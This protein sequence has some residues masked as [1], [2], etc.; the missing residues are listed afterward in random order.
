LRGL[1]RNYGIIRPVNF[2]ENSMRLTIITFAMFATISS[3]AFAAD[4]Q[5]GLWKLTLET[6]VPATPDFPSAPNTMNQCM[7]A[8]D[9]QD[10]AH[11][12]GSAA[13]P[14]ASDCT[15]TE[16]SLVD[17]TLHFKM[18]C[19]GSLGI[20]TQGKITYSATSMEGNLVSTANIMG[21]PTVFHIRI[22]AHRL[23]DC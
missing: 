21:K 20:Q 22:T 8:Q 13:N 2:K 3:S 19:A 7:T 5:P 18:Q 16:K 4:I 12:F 15:F 11:V 1:L 23:G 10:P 9:A 6:R 17:N 14:G